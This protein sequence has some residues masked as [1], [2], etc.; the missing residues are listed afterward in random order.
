MEIELNGEVVTLHRSNYIHNGQNSLEAFIDHK[1]TEG[2]VVYSEPYAK[3]SVCLKE[4]NIPTTE[5]FIKDWSENEGMLAQ[6]INQGVVRFIKNVPTG[7]VQA[8][9]CEIITPLI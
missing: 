7:F 2:E 6:L 3:L 8:A 9:L 1:N 5:I 4:H